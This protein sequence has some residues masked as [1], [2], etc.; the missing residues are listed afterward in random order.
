MSGPA[1]QTD[2]RAM[3][4][5]WIGKTLAFEHTE[6]MARAAEA[7]L[8]RELARR[9]RAERRAERVQRRQQA[10]QRRPAARRLLLGWHR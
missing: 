9:R 3:N 10:A 8:A 7:T 4:D 6:R 5:Y 2:G 1:A